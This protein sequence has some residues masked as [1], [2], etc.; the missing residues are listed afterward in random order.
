[1]PLTD[2]DTD[3]LNFKVV[4]RCNCRGIPTVL[5]ILVVPLPSFR[6]GNVKNLLNFSTAGFPP[7]FLVSP[8]SLPFV[9]KLLEQTSSGDRIDDLLAR[10]I[11]NDG[12][13]VLSLVRVRKIYVA[14]L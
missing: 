2:T 6:S 10:V 8:S 13:C 7:S 4:P 5:T 11:F 9:S 14:R 1:M 12:T 3:H